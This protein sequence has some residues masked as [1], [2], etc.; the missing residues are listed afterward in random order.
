MRLETAIELDNYLKSVGAKLGTAITETYPRLNVKDR[1]TGMPNV[2]GKVLKTVES[3]VEL[4]N[5]YQNNVNNQLVREDKQDNF[6][7]KKQSG[8]HKWNGSRNISVKD[9]DDSVFYFRLGYTNSKPVVSFEDENGKSLTRQELAGYLPV[10]N[11]NYSQ[12]TDKEIV[13]R[14]VFLSSIKEIRI[15]DKVFKD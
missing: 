7:A 8:K 12:G 9:T 6:K 10:K 15:G 11:D 4:N 1:N 14:D 13:V 5:I 3:R 2:F